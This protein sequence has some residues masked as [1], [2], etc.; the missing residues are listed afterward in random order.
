MLRWCVTSLPH[1]FQTTAFGLTGLVTLDMLS[2]LDVP[3]PQ[4]VDLVFLD[5]LHHFPETLSLVDKVRKKY[6]LNNV[7]VYS[8]FR[9]RGVV[10]ASCCQKQ[11]TQTRTT[12]PHSKT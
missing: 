12:I 11:V 2:K 7:H 5:T 1:L 10:P 3:R 6:P 9:G 4:M 8:S